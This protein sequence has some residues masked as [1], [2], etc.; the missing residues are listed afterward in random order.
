LIEAIITEVLA[1]LD[2]KAITQIEKLEGL[3]AGFEWNEAGT[4]N[5]RKAPQGRHGKPKR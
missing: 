4:G 3:R 5:P 1:R 2:K